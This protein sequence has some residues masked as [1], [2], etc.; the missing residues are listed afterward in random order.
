MEKE[1][2]FQQLFSMSFTPML[3]MN[4]DGDIQILNEACCH[5][6]KTTE[7]RLLSCNVFEEPNRFFIEK[8]EVKPLRKQEEEVVLLKKKVDQQFPMHIHI[9]RTEGDIP[10]LVVQW[11]E[12]S[13]SIEKQEEVIRKMKQY[14]QFVQ[15]SQDAFI[16]TRE[17]RIQY[18][19]P[20]GVKLL[21][22]EKKEE[23]IGR[24]WLH[25]IH[26]EHLEIVKERM[27]QLMNGMS[28]RPRVDVKLLTKK[29]V[30][31][32][33]SSA[34]KIKFEGQD[35]IQY[36]IRDVTDRKKYDEMAS[37]SE[38]LTMVS[39]LAAGVAHEIRNPM[40]AIKGFIQLLKA[41][42]QYNEEYNDIML[43]ELNRVESIIQEFLTLAK[44]KIE[45]SYHPKSLNQIIRHVTLLLD[46]HANYKNCRIINEISDEITIFCEENGLKQVFINLI[47]NAL[48]SMSKGTV[49]VTVEKRNEYG[50]VII[51]DEGC[52]I[53]EQSLARLGEP[54]YSTKQTGTGLGLMISYR[55][56]EQHQGHISFASKVGVG[57]KVEIALPYIKEPVNIS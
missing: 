49:K 36:I 56:I 7:E 39:K 1:K 20:A 29:G 55:I 35:A 48:E 40:T 17:G 28:V 52:G 15:Q 57:T 41:S 19:N 44:P 25:F 12:F 37:K 32:I 18:L 13:S 43:E 3:V 2:V 42:K 26:P 11:K 27:V 50:M 24:P 14:K 10:L 31:I 21:G 47:Q 30:V 34:T 51:E 45:N 8:H 23:Y 6:F 9:Q 38:K 46:T 16:V 53:D 33:E 54:F 5:L 4:M 22:G